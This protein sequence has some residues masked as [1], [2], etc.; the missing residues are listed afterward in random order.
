MS[1]PTPTKFRSGQRIVHKTLGPGTVIE[2]EGD[3]VRVELDTDNGARVRTFMASLGTIAMTDPVVTSS[4]PKPENTMPDHLLAELDQT[5]KTR[6]R[7]AAK[8]LAEK[9]D[10]DSSSIAYWR[11]AGKI[12]DARRAAVQAWIAATPPAA[13]AVEKPAPKVKPAKPA[14]SP[15]TRPVTPP[16]RSGIDLAAVF[17]GLGLTITTA[18][19]TEGENMRLVRVA[20]LP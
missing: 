13:V 20:V 9:L 11:Q 1:D 4:T 5:L 12:P 16:A 8:D 6:G 18:W 10:M 19:I 14:K 15:K 17:A 2:A 7:G 3:S